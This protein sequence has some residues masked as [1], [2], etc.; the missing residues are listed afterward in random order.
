VAPVDEVIKRLQQEYKKW[1]PPTVTELAQKNK[2]PFK[3]LISCIL[4]LRTKDDIGFLSSLLE[5][6][7]R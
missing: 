4:S 6:V 5:R 7:M 3:V 2:D 1:K